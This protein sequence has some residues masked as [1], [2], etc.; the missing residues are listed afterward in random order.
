MSITGI[1]VVHVEEVVRYLQV[2]PV[3]LEVLVL[4]EAYAFGHSVELVQRFLLQIVAYKRRQV[5][6]LAAPGVRERHS[7]RV[8]RRFLAGLG[9]CEE[10]YLLLQSVVR[11]SLQELED[12]CSGLLADTEGL[13]AKPDVDYILF[14]WK[15]NYLLGELLGVHRIT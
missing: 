6:R 5:F 9:R 12:A 2:E 15:V 7:Q 14:L 13:G 10:T 11:Y 4:A 1:D 3:A 8:N